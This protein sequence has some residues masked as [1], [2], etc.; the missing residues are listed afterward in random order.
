MSVSA[1]AVADKFD[2]KTVSNITSRAHENRYSQ[3]PPTMKGMQNH[4]RV[5]KSR[6][7]WIA[8]RSAN[9]AALTIP[10]VFEGVY[11]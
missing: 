6:T 8:V 4:V 10:S 3:I 2:W 11:G 9:T 1:G 7:R 5:V